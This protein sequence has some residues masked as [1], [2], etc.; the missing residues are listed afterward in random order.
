MEQN[1]KK[2]LLLILLCLTFLT[3]CSSKYQYK[4][5][6][7]GTSKE[8]LV[9]S[10]GKE[11]SDTK[12]DKNGN[13]FLS[14]EK[15][16]YLGYEG[17]SAYCFS[18][19]SMAFTKWEYTAKD[20]EDGKAV[21]DKIVVEKNKTYGNGFESNSDTNMHLCSWNTNNNSIA[22]TCITENGTTVVSLT[23]ALSDKST[24]GP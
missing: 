17:T 13:E 6:A 21:Y 8:A 12:K 10:L 14:Y 20:Y 3:A 16:P 4:E 22:V 9:D 23:E 19:G 15:C 1:M 2:K 11:P 7:A 24:K 18:D 5:I